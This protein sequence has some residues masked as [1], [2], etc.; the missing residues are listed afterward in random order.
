MRGIGDRLGYECYMNGVSE[1]L[2]WEKKEDIMSF[3]KSSILVLVLDIG[4][5]YSAR[6]VPIDTGVQ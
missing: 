3:K 1:F 2:G 4:N 5:V 6:V